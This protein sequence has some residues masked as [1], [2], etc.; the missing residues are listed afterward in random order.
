[1]NRNNGVR[2]ADKDIEFLWCEWKVRVQKRRIIRELSK[3]GGDETD[4]IV[5]YLKK[6]PITVFPYKFKEKYAIRNVKLQKDKAKN[7]YFYKRGVVNMY[8]KKTYKSEFRAKRYCS[9]LLMEQDMDSPHCYVSHSFYPE[10]ESVIIDIGGAEGFFPIEYL[11]TVKKVY[12]FECSREWTEALQATYEKYR[13]KVFIVNKFVSDCS[14]E[15][16]VSLDDFVKE[17]HLENEKI[18][19]K[20][21]AEGSEPAIID[22]AK[23]F[24]NSD[25]SIK[26]AICTYHC[27]EHE[28]VFRKRFDGWNIENAKGY[29]LYYY[30]FCFG[31]PYIR[32]G[33]LRI[34]N[35]NKVG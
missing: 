33:V 19:I 31:A 34:D 2:L 24:L 35:S 16:N 12:I 1:M 5:D 32:R 21:D 7:M 14:D 20:I 22:G 27:A 4:E 18:F 11:D 17:N 6:H 13:D 29:M 28:S 26:L 23:N 8:L 30:D 25:T 15:T 10:P 9:N 3:Q